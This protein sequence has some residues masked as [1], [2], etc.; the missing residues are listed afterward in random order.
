MNTNFEF[1]V[2]A[3][4]QSNRSWLFLQ[5]TLYPLGQLLDWNISHI[6]SDSEAFIVIEYE[7]GAENWS[8]E[9]VINNS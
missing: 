1:L 2:W 6:A 9:Q 4:C 3:D 7:S 8:I 5:Q